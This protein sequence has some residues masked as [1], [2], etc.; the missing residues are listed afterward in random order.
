MKIILR[1]HLKIRLEQRKIPRNY[2][3]I[4]VMKPDAKYY[5]IATKHQVAVK[6]LKYNEKLRPMAAS[7]DIIIDEIQII[8]IHPVSEQEIENKLKK[9]RWIKDE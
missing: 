1:P 5:D 6:K 8:T 2:P 3:K 4:I 7:Y 9:E